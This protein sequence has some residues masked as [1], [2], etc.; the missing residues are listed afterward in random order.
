MLAAFFGLSASKDIPNYTLRVAVRPGLVRFGRAWTTSPQTVILPSQ[1]A[2]IPDVPPSTS[3]TIVNPP[4]TT[5]PIHHFAWNVNLTGD[6]KLSR[7][8]ALRAGIGEDLVRYR[9]DEVVRPDIGR[10]PYQSWLSKQN[11]ISRGN[12]SYQLGPGIRS[13]KCR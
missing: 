4:P 7:H 11:F 10:P 9:T 1:L 2:G 6:Y 3:R 8:F 13:E 12:W 5:G